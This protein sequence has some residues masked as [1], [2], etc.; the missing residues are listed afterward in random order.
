[1][2][3]AKAPA[4]VVGPVSSTGAVARFRR[5]LTP[6]WFILPALLVLA[7]FIIGPV[8]YSF[9]LSFHE[10]QWNMP[11]F[12]RPFVGLRNYADLPNDEDLT[13]AVGWTLTFVVVSVPIGLVMGMVIS[14]LLNSPYLGRGRLRGV[15]R[16]V[17][18]LPMM[19]AAVVAG[20]MWR[21]LFDPEY[22]P[23]NHLLSFVGA[24][25]V[26]WFSEATAARTAVVVA[27]LWLT[28]PF[29]V[30]VLLAGLQGIPEDVY[31]AGRI[32][33]ASARQLFTQITLPLLRTSI[34]IVLIIRTM[35][36]LRVFDLLF[37]LTEGGP[38]TATATVM[39]YDYLYAFQYYQMGLASAFSF[40]VL[41]V[42]ALITA[43][44]LAVLRRADRD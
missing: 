38:G 22:G 21:M 41:V 19:L 31:E 1:M 5:G 24:S 27:E 32:D 2:I 42:I 23:V 34:A 13:R 39:Y 6:Y 43:V 35:D 40:T 8:A 15:L 29:V 7:M 14:L 3:D 20:F 28:T 30:L 37:I 26:S 10:Y 17:F 12:G 36:A 33:G 25:P 4:R 16:G 44:Y 18:L 11:S 9:W